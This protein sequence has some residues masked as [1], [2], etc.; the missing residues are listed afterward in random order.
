METIQTARKDISASKAVLYMAIE[1]SQ[2]RWVL[3]FSRGTLK[4][5]RVSVAARDIGE[6]MKAIEEARVKLGLPEDARVVSCYEAGRDGFWLHRFLVSEGIENV[7]VDSSSIDVNRK[8]R[9][10]KTDR[11][12]AE[13]LLNK[14]VQYDEGERVWSV[15][16]VPSVEEEDG[17]RGHRELERMKKERT[18]HSN[19]IKG[20][21]VTQGIVMKIGRD[22]EERIEEVRTWDGRRVPEGLKTE[23]LREFE[24]L[25]LLQKQ[26]GKV[27]AEREA[28]LKEPR[29]EAERK[30]AKLTKLL[31]IGPISGWELSKEMFGWRVFKNRREVGGLSGLTPSPYSSGNSSREQGISKSGSG[32]IRALMVELAWRWV[33]RQRGSRLTEWFYER[34]AKGGNRSR[35][36]G[37]V[38]VARKLL[39]ALWRYVEQDVLPEGAILKN[40]SLVVE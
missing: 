33:Y 13:K 31:G 9:R 15:V 26:I 1:M 8:A 27:E 20:L 38:A 19:R 2:R 4:R 29:D 11:L 35:R 36:V 5:R 39:I 37:I 22:F 3:A 24:R 34:F 25:Q 14:L 30:A 16:R 6:L 23:L 7:V 17:R 12:D 18:A 21:L 28:Y 40:G 10:A 32:R